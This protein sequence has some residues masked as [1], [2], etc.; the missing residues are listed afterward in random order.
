MKLFCNLTSKLNVSVQS[1]K[2]YVLLPKNIFFLKFLKL[3]F[4]EG[5]VS[6][7]LVT[8][9]KKIKV[10]LKYCS[11]GSPSFKKIKFLSKPGKIQY[12]SYKELSKLSTGVGL[13]IVSTNKG[14]LT[15]HS[16]IKL[17]IGG[18]ILCYII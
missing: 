10:Y 11:K 3:L 6:R 7:I 9:S 17:K 12:S 4:L 8:N 5:F 16:C 18:T 13:I 1:Y 14:L 15:H 2:S